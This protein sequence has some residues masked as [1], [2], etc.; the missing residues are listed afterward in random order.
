MKTLKLL[1]GFA[2]VATLFTS[3]YVEETHYIDEPSISLNQLLN[4]YDLWYVNINET[5]G[6]GETPFLQVAFTVSFRNGLMYANNNLVG[7]GSQGNGY[8][9]EIGTYDAYDMVLDINHIIDGYDSFDVYQ[10]DNN[11]IELYNPFNDTS[12][13]LEGYQRSNFDYDYVFYDNIHYFLQEYEAWEKTYTSNFGAL[14]DF[15]NENYLQFL[16]GGNDDTFR[17]SQDGN[18]YNP[19]NIYWDF[20]GSYDVGNVSGNMYVKTLTLDYDFFD[21]EFFEL[22]VID[23]NTVELFHSNSGTVYEFKGKGYIQYYRDAPTQGKSEIQSDELKKRK[24]KTKKVENTRENT[25][26]TQK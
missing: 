21:N 24:Q 20:T 6:Y 19:D 5:Q 22:S 7:L 17:S 25:R 23:D 8:G 12:Y 26:N 3:C 16:S 4:S 10:I 14:N 9:V 18:I 1:L 2:F 11:T 15:D 13:F